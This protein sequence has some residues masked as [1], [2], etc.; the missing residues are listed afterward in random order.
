M[1]GLGFGRG[2]L[3][4]RAG[5]QQSGQTEIKRKKNTKKLNRKRVRGR[6]KVRKG[7]LMKAVP[8]KAKV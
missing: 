5:K 6:E 7:Q 8:A 1:E 2:G 4:G 3:A